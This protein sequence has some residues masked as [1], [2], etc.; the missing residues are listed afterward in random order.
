M[1]P[2]PTGAQQARARF[3]TAVS[4]KPPTPEQRAAVNMLQEKVIDLASLI[5]EVV[6]DGRNKSIALT[7]LED[8]H[9]RANRGVFMDGIA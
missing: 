2:V 1:Q 9:M 7:A 3:Q 4:G 5:G 6:P 8:V